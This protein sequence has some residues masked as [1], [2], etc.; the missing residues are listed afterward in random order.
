MRLTKGRVLAVVV[1]AALPL[2]WWLRG[3]SYPIINADVGAGPIIAFGD[4]L[5]A[6]FAVDRDG[7]Y[8]QQLAGLLGT[9]V[10][11]R[12]LSGDTTEGGLARLQHDVLDDDPGIVL[13][14]LGANDFLRRLDEDRAFANFETIIERI[15]QRGALVILIGLDFPLNRSYARRYRELARR[16]GCPFVPDVMDGIL[17]DRDLMTDQVHPNAG[18]YKLWAQRVERVLRPYVRGPN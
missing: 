11:N 14:C 9:P 13:L 3:D 8:P 17:G 18:G 15:Q 1:V 16:K 6:G 4:S 7:A 5:T 12:G 2:A 10:I